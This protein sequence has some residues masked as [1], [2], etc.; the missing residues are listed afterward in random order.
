MGPKYIYLLYFYPNLLLVVYAAI[1]GNMS[2][3]VVPAQLSD[4][5]LAVPDLSNAAVL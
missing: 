3:A 5:K 4:N 1:T 2:P